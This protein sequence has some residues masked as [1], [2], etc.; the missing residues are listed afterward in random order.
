MSD[1]LVAGIDDIPELWLYPRLHLS[2]KP[3]L[4][5]LLSLFI[6]LASSLFFLSALDEAI[7]L[8]CR[9]TEEVL[10]HLLSRLIKLLPLRYL[11]LQCF[12]MSYNCDF[13]LHKYSETV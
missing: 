10:V 8:M 5:T 13:L 11:R 9:P 4:P 12:S 2:P 6:P 3:L 7:K 1:R